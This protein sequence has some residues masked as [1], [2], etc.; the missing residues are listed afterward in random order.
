MSLLDLK[1]AA[2]VEVEVPAVPAVPAV[3]PAAVLA[4]VVGR[5]CWW[6]WGWW[7]WGWR[8]NWVPYPGTPVAIVK[9]GTEFVFGAAVSGTC[10]GR[11]ASDASAVAGARSLGVAGNFGAHL[12]TDV[13]VGVRARRAT[14]SLGD[15]MGVG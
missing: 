2:E 11:A 13:P 10:A 6:R 7:R 4:R 9:K 14:A 15:T 12:G 1:E 5:G 3:P 8:R